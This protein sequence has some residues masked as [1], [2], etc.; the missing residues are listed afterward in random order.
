MKFIGWRGAAAPHP[1]EI[2]P[3]LNAAEALNSAA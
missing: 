1:A 3:L 2:R